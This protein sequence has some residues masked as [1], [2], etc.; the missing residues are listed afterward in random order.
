LK[1]RRGNPL[2]LPKNR[3]GTG[4]CPY[5]DN[6]NGYDPPSNAEGST[7][8]GPHSVLGTEPDKCGL[9]PH[10]LGPYLFP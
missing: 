5:K 6:E 4:A 7:D 1:N 3:A 9:I 10:I 2:W 8:S